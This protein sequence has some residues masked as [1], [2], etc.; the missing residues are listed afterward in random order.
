MLC[1]HRNNSYQFPGIA[2]GVICAGAL[3]IPEDIFLLSA[4]V[5]RN[6][7]DKTFMCTN[8]S[9]TFL[10]TLAKLVTDEDLEMGSLYPPLDT[11]QNC[12]IKIAT[13]IVDYCY[14]KGIASVVPRPKNTEAFIKSQMYEM[15]YTSALPKTYEWPANS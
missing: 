7:F 12:S 13:A 2:L 1:F 9:F 8:P 5:K 14:E 11:I 4:Q 10:Q 15:S 6:L 3:T